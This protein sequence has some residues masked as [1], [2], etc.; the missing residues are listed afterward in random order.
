MKIGTSSARLIQARSGEVDHAVEKSRLSDCL[1]RSVRDRANNWAS[2]S[3]SGRAAIAR[4][5]GYQNLRHA[6]RPS[7]EEG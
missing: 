7:P 4:D 6:L 3:P 2:L 5:P 1:I